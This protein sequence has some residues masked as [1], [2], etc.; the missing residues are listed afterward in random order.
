MIP[1]KDENPTR[2]FPIVTVVL[3]AVNVLIHLYQF[4]LDPRSAWY[5]VHKYGAVPLLITTG[6]DPFPFDGM[7]VDATIL[8]SMF[9]HG[10][11]L[12]LISNVWFLWI[13]GNNVEDVIG[14]VRF[15]FFY[16]ASGV[17]ASAVFVLINP[18]FTSPLIGA[19]G[20]IAGVM[21]GYLMLFPRARVLTLI[22]I[23]IYPLFIWLPAWFFLVYWFVIQLF[24]AGAAAQSNVAW[25]AHVAGFL[26]GLLLVR[27]LIRPVKRVRQG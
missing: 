7:P 3:I 5:F 22:L 8:T 1:L 9:L 14:R 19:S 24:T 10:G 11:I 13:F 17:A 25:E 21:G 20:A 12:H 23:I 6:Q 26:V 27:F 16:L 4:G 18:D 15:L 2:R